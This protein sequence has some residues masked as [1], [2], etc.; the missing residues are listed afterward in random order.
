[1]SILIK[2]MEMPKDCSACKLW[3]ICECMRD[4]P[5]WESI[6]FAVHDGNLLRHKDCSL[7]EVLEPRMGKW[8]VDNGLY[9]C[10]A[11]NH[12]WSELW[13]VETVPLEK[14][15]ELMPY[16]PKCGVKMENAAGVPDSSIGS[17]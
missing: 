12:L 7:A 15:L 8:I 13:W 16:C 5:D 2:G 10:S 4:Y 11:C 6:Y 9:R 3:S 14:M 17:C 1:M